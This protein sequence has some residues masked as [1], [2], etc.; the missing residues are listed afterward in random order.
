MIAGLFAIVGVA[1]ME[2]IS[3]G[4]AMAAH[5]HSD[6]EAVEEVYDNL[7]KR[8]IS[9]DRVIP[10][11]TMSANN[12]MSVAV[13]V[14]GCAV[15]IEM[16]GETFQITKIRDVTPSFPIELHNTNAET[17][18]IGLCKDPYRTVYDG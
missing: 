2:I 14:D 12:T 4:W 1:S 11:P 5:G 18:L 15:V 10:E 6:R 16:N 7:E 13:V 9:E 3:G 17:Q 8:G